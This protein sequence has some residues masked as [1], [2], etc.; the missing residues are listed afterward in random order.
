MT[1]QLQRLNG[2]TPNGE[3]GPNTWALAWTGRYRQ[4]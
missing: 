1:E 3:I 4:P 2:L